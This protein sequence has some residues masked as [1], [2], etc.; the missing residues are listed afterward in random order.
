MRRLNQDAVIAIV[1]L[2]ISGVL[3]WSTF[4]IRTPD[5]GVLAPST[6]P[7]I[8]IIVLAI[9]SVIYLISSIKEGE[10]TTYQGGPADREPGLKAWLVYWQN[11]IICFVLFFVYLF[12]L[13]VLGSLIGGVLF[14]FALMSAIGGFAKKDMGVHAMLALTTVG[15]MWSIFT[16][17]LEVILPTGII[18][19]PF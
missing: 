17:G 9:L 16:Y 14:V 2:L 3:F 15:G 18:F 4:S 8:I 11:P 5:Y 13:P 12:T 1:L 6:W 19:S 7:R 10:G